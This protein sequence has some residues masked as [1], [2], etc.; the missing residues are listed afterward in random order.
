MGTS[1]ITRHFKRAKIAPRTWYT[2]YRPA[3]DAEEQAKLPH[4]SAESKKHTHVRPFL[5]C[6]IMSPMSYLLLVCLQRSCSRIGNMAATFSPA[7]RHQPSSGLRTENPENVFFGRCFRFFPIEKR[8]GIFFGL[9][10]KKR[11]T[12]TGFS[13]FHPKTIRFRCAFT[14]R[15]PPDRKRPTFR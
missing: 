6:G 10:A 7:P 4:H 2:K 8:H 5:S 3:A 13:V 11:L 12:P 1:N 14:L 9:F 15:N